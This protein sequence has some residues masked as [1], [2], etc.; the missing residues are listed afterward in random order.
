VNQPA[1]LASE[2]PRLS[3]VRIPAVGETPGSTQ[4]GDAGRFELA[5]ATPANALPG[6]LDGAMAR[7]ARRA[8]ADNT[9]RAYE[10]D[11]MH[12]A[13]W[14]ATEG[15]SPLPAAPA[16]VAAYLTAHVPPALAVSTLRRRL[17]AIS[18][19]HKA[20]G[21]AE[22]EL[23]TR[24]AQVKTVWAGIR[25]EHGVAP[26]KVRAAR[27]KVIHALVASLGDKPIYLRDQALLL[28]GF[29]GA[30]RR[31]ELVSLDVADVTGDDDGLRIVLRRSKT[32]QE[33]EAKT[34]GLP[35]GSNP[36]TCP[37]RAW[38]AWR[39]AAALETGPAFR[40]I[41][42]HGRIARTRLSDRAVANMIRRRALAAGL[43]G[44]FAGHSLRAGFATEGYAQ[45]T[46]ELAV[47][48]HGRWRSAAVMRGYVEEGGLWT[49]NAAAR[50]GL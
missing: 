18:V 35:Y 30:L 11:L 29:A 1:V 21:I 22:A 7:Y 33:G 38:R 4:T 43:D 46:P 37:V 36:A 48:R 8:R 26:R 42:R 13:G 14:C 28:I 2:N 16:T 47:M 50:L 19:M 27:T 25:R 44:R 39:A 24:A 9:W 15:L 41:T 10:S 17:A 23:P 45:G 40:A 6:R 12:F 3:E 5:A 31:S 32:D 20:A 49:D 34:L